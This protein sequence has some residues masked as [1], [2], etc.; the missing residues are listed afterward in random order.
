MILLLH[1]KTKFLCCYENP[2][3]HHLACVVYFTVL[4]STSYL[5]GDEVQLLGYTDHLGHTPKDSSHLPMDSR[6]RTILAHR[7][8]CLRQTPLR[9]S[10][11]RQS[12]YH[13]TREYGGSAREQRVASRQICNRYTPET[14]KNTSAILERSNRSYKQY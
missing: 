13:Q 5:Q 4:S 11:R 12:D 8:E 6:H 3:K 9:S 14:M 10:H 1:R 2:L 7:Q